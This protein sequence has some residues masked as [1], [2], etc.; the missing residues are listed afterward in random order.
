MHLKS[1]SEMKYTSAFFMLKPVNA[2]YWFIITLCISL[3]CFFLWAS[4]A[5]M[6]DV[7]KANIILRP[8]QTVSS[9]KCVSSGQLL[10]KYY[11]NDQLVERGSL[12]FSLD[13]TVYE[14]ELDAYKKEKEKNINDILTNDIFIETL[15]S[16]NLPDVN[17]NTDSYIKASAYITELKRYESLI[18]DI[19]NKLER[20]QNKPEG[21]LIPQ[22]IQDLNSQLS[23]NLLAFDGWKT[24][25]RIQ[26]FELSKQLITNK[27]TI[28]SRITELER[29][30]KNST[31]YAP[32]DG[33]ISETT[34]LNIGDYV[35][36]GE[37]ILKIVPQNENK[38]KVDVYIDPNYIA[39][40][41]VGNPLKIKFPGLP[42]SRYGLVETE[43]TVIP[44]DVSY[45]NGSPMFI[46][47]AEIQN[48]ILTAKN[49]QVAKLIPG[50]TAEGRIVTD[51]CTVIEM[52]LR[53]LDFVN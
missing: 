19:K 44:P 50:I 2:I 8:T 32:I 36:A 17:Q 6:D 21:L 52:I 43:I 12:L 15:N 1:F 37:E 27:N 25:Q 9:V 47:G 24:S 45:I 4:I 29:I 31:I 51:R 41:T 35:L 34:K 33:R 28:E 30:M 39:R 53:K 5:P 20:E 13:T 18:T 38:L 42:P 46:A 48:A 23:Q 10:Y 11:E 26:A 7:I 16:E 22:N 3:A 49:G 40:V 14:T